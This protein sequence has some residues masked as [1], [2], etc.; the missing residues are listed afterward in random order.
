M[1]TSAAVG[2]AAPEVSEPEPVSAVRTLSLGWLAMLPLF[3]AYELALAHFGGVRRN[4][5]ELL[6][7]LA[8][9]PLGEYAALA[10]WLGLALVAAIAYAVTARRGAAVLPGVARIVLEGLGFAVVLGPALVFGLRALGRELDVSWD[11]TARPPEIADA[12]MLFGGAAWEELLF[13]VAVYSFSY[14]LIARFYA[15]LD[16]TAAVG[17]VLAELGGLGLSSLAFAG[18]HFERFTGWI[19]PGGRAWDPAAFAWFALAGVVLGVIFR[20]RGAGV[21]AWAHGLFNV[22]LWIGIDPD[23]VR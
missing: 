15:A 8:L 12:A 1:S 18:A 4:T 16:G 9:R 6:L 3:L 14:W 7:G 5:G 2:S 17:R 23:V 13:R 20:W 11:P 21:A 22:A 10:R 19:G